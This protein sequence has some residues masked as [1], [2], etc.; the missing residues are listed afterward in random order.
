MTIPWFLM[1]AL[2]VYPLL[3]VV[4]SCFNTCECFIILKLKA[5]HNRG[6]YQRILTLFF[7]V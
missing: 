2:G 5:L 7:H 6:H 4:W 3:P 1:N